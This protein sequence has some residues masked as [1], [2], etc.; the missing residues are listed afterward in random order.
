MDKSILKDIEVLEKHGRVKCG[1]LEFHVATG[2]NGEKCVILSLFDGNAGFVVEATE[3]EIP[4]L[5]RL[6][7]I[8]SDQKKL[9]GNENRE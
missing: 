4:A 5:A 8:M 7:E 2:E 1:M 9:K 6:A 3:E